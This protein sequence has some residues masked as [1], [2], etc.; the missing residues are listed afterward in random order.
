MG[1]ALY[2]R[3]GKLRLAYAVSIISWCYLLRSTPTVPRSLLRRAGNASSIAA[4]LFVTAHNMR[5]RVRAYLT[6]ARFGRVGKYAHIAQACSTYVRRYIRLPSDA[7]DKLARRF[8]RRYALYV[9]S[10]VAN[11]QKQ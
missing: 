10:E 9:D 3:L 1:L 8:S 2:E 11:F 6:G 5:I 7:E 4:S